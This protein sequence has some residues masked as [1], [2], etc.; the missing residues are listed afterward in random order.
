VQFDGSGEAPPMEVDLRTVEAAL[1]DVGNSAHAKPDGSFTIPRLPA[2]RMA[3]LAGG[4]AGLYVESVT[5]SGRTPTDGLVDLTNGA[6]GPLEITLAKGTAGIQGK[7][8]LPDAGS[9]RAA[10]PEATAV[11]VS[12]DGTTG[13]TRA[14][15]AA[16]DRDGQ[17]QFSPVPPGRWYVFAVPHFDEGLWQNM[18]FVRAVAGEGAAVQV[19]KS[20]SVQTEISLL[21]ME[22]I[23]RAS[24][25]VGQ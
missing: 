21:A 13:N 1:F 16:L 22:T 17:F 19:E 8:R 4:D 20:G 14:R 7:L 9:E 10:V 3:V 23:R 5:V 12:A 2:R 15:G 24:E 25:A 11:L 18:E 6:V